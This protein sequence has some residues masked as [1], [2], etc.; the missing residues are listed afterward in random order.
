M[1]LTLR[2]CRV[3]K[4]LTQKEASEYIGVNV[5]TLKKWEK[6]KAFP[7]KPQYIDKICEVYGVKYDD[8]NFI[9]IKTL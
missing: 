3:N 9:P 2:A 5:E 8:I 6:G 4:S 1:K 7:S